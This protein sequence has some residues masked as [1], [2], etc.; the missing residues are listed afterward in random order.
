MIFKTRCE[1]CEKIIKISV[2]EFPICD[3]CM[4]NLVNG[5]EYPYKS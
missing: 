4:D 5:G 3:E 1:I 2:E